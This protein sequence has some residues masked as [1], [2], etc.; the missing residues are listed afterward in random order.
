[1]KLDFADRLLAGG[2]PEISTQLQHAVSAQSCLAEGQQSLPPS[3]GPKIRA[4]FCDRRG[5]IPLRH[6]EVGRALFAMI[7]INRKSSTTNDCETIYSQ[8]LARQIDML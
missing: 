7:A 6:C 3:Q 4:S 2:A 1:M 5:F 8:S